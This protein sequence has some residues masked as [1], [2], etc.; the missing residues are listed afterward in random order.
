MSKK[1]S[2]FPKDGDLRGLNYFTNGVMC[3]NNQNEVIDPDDNPN[4]CVHFLRHSWPLFL[5]AGIYFSLDFVL[6]YSQPVK[7]SMSC[8]MGLVL[9]HFGEKNGGRRK[10]KRSRTKKKHFISDEEEMSKIN[11]TNCAIEI[12]Y[13][14]LIKKQ[15]KFKICVNLVN[16]EYQ[17]REWRSLDELVSVQSQLLKDFEFCPNLTSQWSTLLKTPL[18][19]EDSSISRRQSQHRSNQSKKKSLEELNAE[20]RHQQVSSILFSFE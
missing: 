12:R 11:M 3:I 9:M 15:W 13:V 2:L 18:N 1:S 7:V 6:N 5:C 20:L 17:W 10:G 4:V 8:F 16:T 19:I 14:K